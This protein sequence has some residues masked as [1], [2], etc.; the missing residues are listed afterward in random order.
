M[1]TAI[2]AD[3]EPRLA[4]DLARRLAAR[5]PELQVLD[6]AHNGP[7]A[8]ELI[9]ARTPDIAFLD[10]RMPGLTGLQVA[11]QINCHVVFVTAYDDYAVAAFERE[12]AD[13][14]LKPV[15]DDRLD[16]CIERL[17]RR[18]EQP[19]LDAGG[20]LAKLSQLMAPT[21][22]KL[23][24]IRASQ[25]EQIRLVAVADVVYFQATDKYT[26][27]HTADA[28]L[29]IRTPLKELLDSLDPQQ[30][31]QI[32]RGTIVNVREI[33]EVRRDFRGRLVVHLRSRPERLVVSRAYVHLFKQM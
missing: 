13:Y 26:A 19:P 9:Q 32:H 6:I 17:R 20:L 18:L 3:D 16:G 28:E 11:A 21:T 2:I 22:P 24:W 7:E 8:V 1:P 25:G 31:W 23:D 4:D 14:L 33:A 29:L 10:I 15:A 30:Y 5:W 12:A 27:V